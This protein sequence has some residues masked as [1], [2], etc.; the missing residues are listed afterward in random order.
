LA[1]IDSPADKPGR[2]ENTG[3]TVNAALRA[4]ASASPDCMA[5]RRREIMDKGDMETLARGILQS[6]PFSALLGARLHRI[7]PGEAEIHL[8]MSDRLRQQHGFAHGGVISYLADNAITFAGGLALGGD[9]LTSEFKINY[10]KPATG[11]L[12]IARAKAV[13]SGRTQAACR[14]DVFF[15]ADGQETLCAIAQGTV[16]AM[17]ARP[18]QSG[19]PKG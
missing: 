11:S 3:K 12:L 16:V 6:Q 13:S 5:G 17:P 2:L 7:G 9:A 1:K 18:S 19:G 14:C 4:A 15:E 8:P 10:V